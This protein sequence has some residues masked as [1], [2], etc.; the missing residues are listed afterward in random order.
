M[1]PQMPDLSRHPC[2]NRA[3]WQASTGCRD[4]SGIWGIFDECTDYSH[5]RFC[6]PKLWARARLGHQR[7]PLFDHAQC[8]GDPSL[9]LGIDMVGEIL[10][11]DIDLNVGIGAVVLYAP[12]NIPKP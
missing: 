12:T 10:R 9:Q 7:R 1:I 6:T 11:R 3:A 8:L 4:K 2:G 5:L